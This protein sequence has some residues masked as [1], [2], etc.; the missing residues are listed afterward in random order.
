MDAIITLCA[1][2]IR[3]MPGSSIKVSADLRNHPDIVSFEE[4]G[5]ISINGQPEP[6][7]EPEPTPE[8]EPE[9]AVDDS[10]LESVLALSVVKAKPE[11]K[12]L[13]AA[14]LARATDLEE[15]GKARG[16]MLDFLDSLAD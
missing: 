2:E 5:R 8:P 14:E 4:R 3:L 16:S 9:P 1:G 7:P 11:L 12:K 15:A 10:K 6:E 13:S